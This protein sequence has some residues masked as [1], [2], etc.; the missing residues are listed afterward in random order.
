MTLK[1]L[2]AKLEGNA[3]E[4]SQLNA[5]LEESDAENKRL[6]S[7]RSSERIGPPVSRYNNTY[8]SC[9]MEAYLYGDAF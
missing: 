3:A 7:E 6:R 8:N 2:N 4:I 5:K 9:K 1:L